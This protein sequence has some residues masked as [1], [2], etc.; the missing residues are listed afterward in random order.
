MQNKNKINDNQYDIQIKR[1]DNQEKQINFQSNDPLS[2]LN[3]LLDNDLLK[4]LEQLKDTNKSNIVRQKI[5][6][7]NQNQSNNIPQSSNQV[8]FNQNVEN[9]QDINILNLSHINNLNLSQEL[10]E[11]NSN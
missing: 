1:Q 6:M 7:L 10:N 4:I 5:L 9:E 3:Q 2:N 11:I 8:I